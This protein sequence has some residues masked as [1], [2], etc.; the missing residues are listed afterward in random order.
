MK[1]HLDL[2]YLNNNKKSE[3]YNINGIML[4]I[5]YKLDNNSILPLLTLA[6]KFFST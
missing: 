4:K 3:K 1:G 6:T 2:P 5:T